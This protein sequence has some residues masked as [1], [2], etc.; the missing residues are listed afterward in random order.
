MHTVELCFFALGRLDANVPNPQ[1]NVINPGLERNELVQNGRHMISDHPHCVFC[2]RLLRIKLVKVDR[3]DRAGKDRIVGD[4]RPGPGA[5]NS[6]CD[7]LMGRLTI[8]AGAN[9]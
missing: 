2:L 3:D 9:G 5:N 4:R 8:R 7:E 6:E 1:C